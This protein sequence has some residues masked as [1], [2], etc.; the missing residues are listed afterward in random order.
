MNGSGKKLLTGSAFTPDG[1]DG[2]GISY[3]LG[4][5]NRLSNTTALSEDVAIGNL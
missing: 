5:R 2:V 3:F 1:N 4:K